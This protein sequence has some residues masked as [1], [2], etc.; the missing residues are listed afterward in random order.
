MGFNP[1]DPR[2]KKSKWL[3]WEDLVQPVMQFRVNNVTIENYAAEGQQQ[4]LKLTLH[5]D[6]APMRSDGTMPKPLGLNATNREVLMEAWGEDDT[7][8]W[9]GQIVELRIEKTNFQGKRV[10]CIRT[11][12][13]QPAAQVAQPQQPAPSP[14]TSPDPAGPGPNLGGASVPDPAPASTADDPF[15]NGPM[16]EQGGEDLPF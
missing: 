13:T 10:N 9:I 14:A 7:D 3:G 5:L 2:L 11:Y 12:P 16:G 1:N 15:G 6:G 4:D 8:T